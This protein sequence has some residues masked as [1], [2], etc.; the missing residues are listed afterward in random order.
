MYKA[1]E[2]FDAVLCKWLRAPSK[3]IYTYIMC[4]YFISLMKET[5]TANR[6]I[7]KTNVIQK[8]NVNR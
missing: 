5:F 2:T 6:E 3:L 4:L 8:E 7:E 1:Y